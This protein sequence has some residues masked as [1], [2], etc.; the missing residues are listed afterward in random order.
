MSVQSTWYMKRLLQSKKTNDLAP[1]GAKPSPADTFV[2]MIALI[3][4]KLGSMKFDLPSLYVL[5]FFE[6]V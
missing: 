4:H 2:P 5:N 3:Y 1:N 6:K